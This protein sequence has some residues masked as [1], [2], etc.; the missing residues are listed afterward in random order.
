MTTFQMTRLRM[1]CPLGAHKVQA[2]CQ[3]HVPPVIRLQE[4]QVRSRGRG[5]GARGKR[6]SWTPSLPLPSS[7]A[8]P[9]DCPFPL[10]HRRRT[11][12]T[13]RQVHASGSQ[14]FLPFQGRREKESHDAHRQL[15]SDGRPP[16][17]QPTRVPPESRTDRSWRDG[18][19]RRLG[20]G[21]GARG[22]VA[23]PRLDPGQHQAGETGRDA[24]PGLAVGSADDRSPDDAV[25]RDS[26]SSWGSPATGSSA[27]CIPT[28][29]PASPT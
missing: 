28:R 17:S 10:R 13:Y 11:R 24:H 7:P 20:P 15:W 3:R 9:L 4:Q 21:S 2:I 25:G 8:I 23:V 14:G 1:A 18:P 27:T 26:S 6:H 5:R 29:R 12:G 19:C 22:N 16:A